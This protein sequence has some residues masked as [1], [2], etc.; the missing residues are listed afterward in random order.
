MLISP[1]VS[2]PDP[3]TQEDPALCT[4]MLEAV[5][6]LLEVTPSQ[7]DLH[8]RG[9]GV[10]TVSRGGLHQSSFSPRYQIEIGISR[11]GMW[12]LSH[13]CTPTTLIR[14]VS[15]PTHRMVPMGRQLFISC[16][17]GLGY[18][19]GLVDPP[20]STDSELAPGIL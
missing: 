20:F 10:G 15:S 7:N 13:Y 6:K 18:P 5:S 2:P 8:P 3:W 1:L 9:G 14:G 12:I 17:T 4:A 19:E 11:E 16:L